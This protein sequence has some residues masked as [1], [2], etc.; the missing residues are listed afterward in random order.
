MPEKGD[1]PALFLHSCC[2]PCSTAVIE[3]LYDDNKIT[4]FFYNPNITDAEEYEKR[5]G[6]QTDFIQSFN[7]EHKGETRVGF[8]E[9]DY[10]PESFYSAAEGLE[11][12]PEGGARCE[13]CFRLRLERTAKAAAEAG[14]DC[15]TTTLT[16][17]PHKD[18]TAI[19][20]IGNEMAEKYGVPFLD[21]NFREQGGYQR[22]IELS[23]QYGLYR[24]DHCGCIFAKE[25][26]EKNRKQ[27]NLHKGE[28]NKCQA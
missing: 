4:V 28:Q 26:Q 17:S 5:K 22:S 18:Y 13:K 1:K 16:V 8:T 23:K 3:R 27:K 14:A 12:E 25:A 11:D 2:G 19:S 21:M 10:D 20:A 15:F 9:G 24:Q 7:E 6:A